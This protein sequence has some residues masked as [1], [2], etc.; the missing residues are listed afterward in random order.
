MKSLFPVSVGRIVGVGQEIPFQFLLTVRI[1]SRHRLAA[2]IQ[3]KKRPSLVFI[4]E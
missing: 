1:D 3:E 4:T 2:G